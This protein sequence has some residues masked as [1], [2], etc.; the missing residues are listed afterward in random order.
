M[1]WITNIFAFA[2]AIFLLVGIHESGHYWVAKHFGVKIMR[3][4]IGLGRP[5]L[6][7]RNKEG[8]E[9]VL[10]CIPIGGYVKMEQAKSLDLKPLYQRMAIVFAGPLA[11]F[12]A[13]I[14]IYTVIAL[15][16]LKTILP[17]LGAIEP[18]QAAAQAGLKSGDRVTGL[19]G[20]TV[21]DWQT[22]V[23]K[24]QNNPGHPLLMTV[25]RG[26][27]ELS[28]AV[29]PDI[30]PRSKQGFI[31]AHLGLDPKTSKPFMQEKWL[32]FGAAL[33][34]GVGKTAHHSALTVKALR[35]MIVGNISIE[36]LSGPISIAKGAGQ[37]AHL[38]VMA[39]FNFLAFISISLGVMNCLPIPM[40]DG[41]HILF[42]IIEGLTGRP[43]SRSTQEIGMRLGFA[44]MLIV[45]TI[46]FYNDVLRLL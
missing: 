10:G 2:V 9:F 14:L 17:V 41:G 33:A 43:L 29:T 30:H 24:I 4:S 31:G 25:D 34:H 11:N 1:D 3:F 16:G 36:Q 27:K 7:W 26:G 39:F 32:S 44:T 19:D 22:L 23:E 8:T 13:A 38:G 28:I 40:L 21:P 5:L 42:Y 6:R 20:Q 15:V 45:M 37:T 12:M 35:N 46:A 18:S